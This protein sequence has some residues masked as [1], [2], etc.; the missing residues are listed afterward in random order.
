MG[1]TGFDIN[2]NERNLFC[3]TT[4]STTKTPL[5]LTLCEGNPP[6]PGGLPVVCSTT[7][8]PSDVVWGQSYRSFRTRDGYHSSFYSFLTVMHTC[9]LIVLSALFCL[10]IYICFI[11]FFVW[12]SYPYPYPW[13][14]Q[15]NLKYNRNLY[16]L[17]CF[18][19]TCFFFFF[20]FFGG[21]GGYRH[22]KA[23]TFILYRPV[24]WTVACILV[25]ITKGSPRMFSAD[26][27][28]LHHV[29]D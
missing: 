14:L 7:V 17:F 20:F 10:V 24:A 21:G 3:L 6:V 9:I 28:F 25:F 4:T 23:R 27:C 1:V 11:Q 8:S 5:S 19:L 13:V 12:F 2:A 29:P 18:F 15:C 16:V 26:C 22:N